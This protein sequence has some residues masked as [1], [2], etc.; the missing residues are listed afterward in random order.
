MADDQVERAS[1]RRVATVMFADISGF[2][3]MSERLDPEEVTAVVNR[4]FEALEAAV[5]SHGGFVDK[6]IGDCIMAVFGA[7]AALEDAPKQAVN[8]AIEM[9]NHIARLNEEGALAVP[10]GLHVGINSGLVLAGRVGGAVKRDFTVLGD[11]VNLASRLKDASP[12]G[13]IYVGLQTYRHTRPHFEFRKTARLSLKGKQ[14]AVSAYEVMSVRERVHRPR[15][16]GADRMIASAMVGRE[17]ELA[18]IRNCIARVVAGAGAIVNVVGDA[19][20]GKSRLLAEARALEEM[21]AATLL[22]GRSLSVGQSLSF[23]PFVDLL[24]HWAGI[25]E[26]DDEAEALEK[27]EGAV[28]EVFPDGVEEYVPFIATLMGMRSTGRHAE[29]LKGIQGEALEK[30][31]FK[32]VRELLGAMAAVRPLVLVFE[33]VHWADLSSM[34]LLESVLR[35]VAESP[36]VFVHVFRPDYTQTGQRLLALARETY[37]AHAVEIQLE[38]LDDASCEQLIR[39]LLRLDELPYATR[40]LIARK[41]EGNPFYIEE[42]LRALIDEGAV[43][44]RDDRFHVTAKVETAVI[45]ETIQDVVMARIEHLPDPVRR[46]LQ[47][48]SVIGRSAPYRIIASVAPP[49]AELG[50]ALA[51]LKKRQLLT[52]RRVGDE[53]EYVFKHALAQET[54]YASLLQRTRKELHLA[55][56]GSIETLFADRLADFYG[57]LSY[58]FSRAESPEKAEEYLFK[59]GDEAARAAA[60]SEALHYFR[61]ASRLY[62]A[63]HG[64]GGD[65]AKKATLERN[66]GQ[67]LMNTGHLTESIDHFNRA[68]E[69]LGERVARTPLAIARKFA[70]DLPVVLRE[71]YL[72]PRRRPSAEGKERFRQALQIRMN[73]TR[74]QSTSDTRRLLFDYFDSI[75]HMNRYDPRTIEEASPNY[76]GFAVLFAYSGLSFRLS[77]RVLEA[78]RSLLRADHAQDVFVFRSMRFVHDFL[79]GR[80]DED[81][82]IDEALV[83]QAL[84][85]G[86]L[87]E[88]N[89]YLGL[90]CERKVRQG[91]FAAAHHHIEQLCELSESYGYSF[92]Q[93]TEYSMRAFV[94]LEQRRLAEALRAVD[95]YYLSRHEDVLK[96][97]AL[98]T[99]AKAE[100]LLGDRERAGKALLEARGVV[101]RLGRVWTPYHVSAYLMSRFLL[102]VTDLE[103][104][105]RDGAPAARQVGK[106]AR[107]SAR[108]AIRIAAKV[109]RERAEAYKLA[110]R[111]CWLL[112]ERDRALAWWSRS[113]AE[114]QRLGALPEVARTFAEVGRRLPE[115]RDGP[116]TFQG[117]EPEACVDRAAALF[118]QLGLDWDLE[119]LGIQA[120]VEATA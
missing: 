61:E 62:F 56:A 85:Y 64:E 81:R 115:R 57:M 112:G 63:I 100:I 91:D 69:F 71:L 98:A 93:S 28:A 116:R 101:E 51:Y 30:L 11:A 12:T 102:D 87:W 31:I 103:Q 97:L 2:T 72:S 119:Q 4:C 73:R 27:L 42:V 79:E 20:I 82:A 76:A 111:L 106:R 46:L 23:H 29:R 25:A 49:G 104:C 47:L 3:A 24:R 66:I 109:A 53:I 107:R 16:A 38:P 60:S 17:H 59:A 21:K 88:V 9:R 105:L 10:I 5:R 22:E 94:L 96:L 75:R 19:G 77:R 8:A 99:R 13:A 45:P 95:R 89:T 110:G 1:E 37:Q 55:V 78:S 92:A 120:E 80:W 50:S 35:L 52:D 15:F 68:L 39:N 44:Y 83:T 18:R 58:H 113:A 32:T 14:A 74:A 108:A 65:P 67:A 90:N 117:L 40:A 43:E 114:G 118:T 70:S 48:I 41:A 86:Q 33:D 36:I 54:I 26:E 6:Y 84:R 34:K 7:P